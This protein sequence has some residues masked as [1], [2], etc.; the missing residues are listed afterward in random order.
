SPEI[1][2]TTP[3][4]KAPRGRPRSW[5]A[6][7]SWRTSSRRVSSRSSPRATIWRTARSNISTE[8]TTSGARSPPRAMAAVS[9]ASGSTHLTAG[10]TGSHTMSDVTVNGRRYRLP[11]RPTVVVCFDGCDPAYIERGLADGILPTIA[12]FL[13][14]GFYAL[15]DAVVPTFTNP[16]NVS[17]VTGAPPAVHGI[18]GNYY[19]DRA[20]G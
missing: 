15:A 16:N 18:S 11:V 19:L 9:A 4:A 10:S 12:G 8:A 7:R 20:S 5:P 13:K 2:S 17:I 6:A 3:C 14:G 1:S